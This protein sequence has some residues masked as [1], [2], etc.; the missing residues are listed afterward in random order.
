MTLHMAAEKPGFLE[1]VRATDGCLFQMRVF[2]QPR[3]P[4]APVLVCMPA[5]GTKG[6]IYVPFASALFEAGFQVAVGELR[7]HGTSSVR[8]RS[9][10]RYGFH[11]MV[12][13]D[14]PAL[15]EATNRV[16]PGASRFLVGHSLGG[17]LGMLYLS[18]NVG[19]AAGAIL[20][21]APS[22]YYRAWPFPLNVG[23]LVG[24]HVALAIATCV[25]YFPGSKLGFAGNEATQVMR[26]WTRQIRT[27]SYRPHASKDGFEQL[28]AELRLPV[29]AVTIAQ[30]RLAP[31]SAIAHLCAKLRNAAVDTWT[32]A[33]KHTKRSPPHFAWVRDSGPLV[34]RIKRFVD[35]VV[36]TS[37][38]REDMP[39]PRRGASSR[40]TRRFDRWFSAFSERGAC[41][42]SCCRHVTLHR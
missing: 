40:L 41:C 17:Q 8:A 1:A 5:M 13:Y 42:R 21:A 11:E 39:L 36:S 15:F 37:T 22:C 25:G 28:L 18:R 23:V 29:L 19:A 20:V 24:T 4:H 34:D 14:Y 12:A 33:P 31:D 26:D 35:R 16:F 10:A 2:K 9:G 6:D 32:Y 3:T 27:G 7:G 30:D 38:A